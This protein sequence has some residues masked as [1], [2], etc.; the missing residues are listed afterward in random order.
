MFRRR[1][2]GGRVN[3]TNGATVNLRNAKSFVV[4]KGAQLKITKGN[5][6]N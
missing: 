5:I 1:D 2:P 6:L 4:P 3:I